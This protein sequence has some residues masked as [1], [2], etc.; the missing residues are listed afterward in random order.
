[1]GQALEP[2]W[3]S[4]N[5][6]SEMRNILKRVLDVSRESDAPVPIQL[7]ER[8]LNVVGPLAA[9]YDERASLHN[10]GEQATSTQKRGSSVAKLH[11]APAHEILTTREIEVLRLL[12]LGMSNNQIAERLVVSTN[13]VNTHNQSIFGKLGVKSR[14]GATRYALEYHLV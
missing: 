7:E 2:F 10:R 4:E 13:T 14:S 11:F 6:A 12:A 1:M 3:P 8:A 5:Y 9:D